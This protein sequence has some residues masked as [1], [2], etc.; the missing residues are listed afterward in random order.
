MRKLFAALLALAFV[1]GTITPALSA[2]DP[3]K[4]RKRF[5]KCKTCHSTSPGVIKVGPSLHCVVGRKAATAAKFKYSKDM[6][7]GGATGLVW[8]ED[9]IFAYLAAPKKYI[10]ALI[11]KKKANL[12]M[13][14][15]FP[16]KTL[17]ENIIAYL[18]T[19]CG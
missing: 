1:A 12:K 6:K 14:N 17:R 10:G 5:G 11:G 2:G 3:N 4:G 16:Q 9:K 15:K 8:T 13:F 19:K 7:A 18:K